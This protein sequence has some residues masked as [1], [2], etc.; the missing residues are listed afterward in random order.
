MF[1]IDNFI[2]IQVI[3]ALLLLAFSPI[4][5]LATPAFNRQQGAFPFLRQMNDKG[6]RAVLILVAAFCIGIAGNRLIDDSLDKFGIEGEEH[7]TEAYRSITQGI[8]GT[9]QPRS[10][11]LA[12]FYV[13]D[14][15]EY[16]RGWLERHKSFMR[17]L[18][19]MSFSCLLFLACMLVYRVAQRWQ[20]KSLKPRYSVVHFALALFLFLVFLGAYISESTH[21]Y[22]RVCEL[23]TGVP[24]CAPEKAI[25]APTSPNLPNT[26]SP[27]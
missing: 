5:F 26:L 25:G 21:Y 2:E 23:A 17:V 14:E 27:S 12:E 1:E 10:I 15:N 19:G 18:R 13:A 22:R 8:P 9:P 6:A 16:A 4:L 7:Y 24:K 20:P 3:G 11:K